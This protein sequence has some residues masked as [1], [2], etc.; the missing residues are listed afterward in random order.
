M[1]TAYSFLLRRLALEEWR[2][3]ARLFGGRRFA[4]FPA[5]VAGVAA[6]TATFLTLAEVETEALVVGL[7]VLVGLVGLQVGTVGLVGRDALEDLLGDTTLLIYSARTL[8]ISTRR[9]LVAFLIKDV[10]YY[11]ILFVLPL[12]FGLVP[13][14]ILGS[15]AP[16]RIGLVAATAIWTFA[17]GVATSLALIGIYTRTRMGAILVVV[18]V[19]IVG[20]LRGDLL[21]D[22][23]PYALTVTPTVSTAIISLVAVGVLG[24]LGVVLFRFERRTPARTAANRFRELHRVLG[25][26][27]R[28]GTLSK[29]LL[30]VHRSSGGVW[31]LAFSQGVVFVVLAVLLD[32]VPRVVPVRVQPGLAIAAILALGTFTTY[33]WLCQFEDEAFYLRYPVTLSTV[34][35]G[36]L[37]AFLLLAIPVGLAYLALGAV[38]FSAGTALL[39]AVVFVPLSLYVFGVTAHVA[40]LQPNELLFDTPTFALFTVAT[41]FIL[42]P[43]VVAAIAYP[44]DPL[45]YG[46][47]AVGLSVGAGTVGLIL[48]RRAG[49]RWERRVLAGS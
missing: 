15:L 49:D 47:G 5:F 18:T 13:L 31:K 10:G 11:A 38:V 41:G 27:D 37:L 4:L 14:V 44:T 12:V 48:Y 43:L 39:G 35:R 36:K 21:L 23:T 20:A 25:D 16:V 8:P 9:L 7:H 22:A 26:L 45:V 28:Q 6:G 3:H 24:A 42:V 19:A 30:D 2:L 32:A 46:G 17:L 34:F 29:S 40:G 1:S 33:N